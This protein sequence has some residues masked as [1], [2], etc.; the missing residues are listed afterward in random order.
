VETAPE[1]LITDMRKR[2]SPSIPRPRIFT[3]SLKV[4]G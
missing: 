2:A 4:H 3:L 1:W